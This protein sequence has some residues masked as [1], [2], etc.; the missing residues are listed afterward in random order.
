MLRSMRLDILTTTEEALSH[1][2]TRM[3]PSGNDIKLRARRH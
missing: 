2:T 1:I 3:F